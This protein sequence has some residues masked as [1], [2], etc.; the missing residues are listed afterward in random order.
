VEQL[1]LRELQDL[2]VVQLDLLEQLAPQEDPLVQ[3]DLLVLEQLALL[4]QQVRQVHK[5]LKEYKVF[6]EF[7]E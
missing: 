4:D 3:P 1:V 2:Q 5:E 6:K 7:R